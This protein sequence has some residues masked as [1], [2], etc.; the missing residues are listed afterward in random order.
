MNLTM[1]D[2]VLCIY[3]FS[4]FYGVRDTCGGIVMAF[5]ARFRSLGHGWLLTGKR[6]IIELYDMSALKSRHNIR[7]LCAYI[8]M[9]NA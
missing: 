6:I 1:T 8:T 7:I 2:E 9:M 4:W 3:P 5:L